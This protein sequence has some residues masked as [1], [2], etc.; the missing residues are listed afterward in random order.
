MISLKSHPLSSSKQ[1]IDRIVRVCAAVEKERERAAYKILLFREP[2]LI[3]SLDLFRG[4]DWQTMLFG[5]HP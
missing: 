3:D 5:T 4:F 1:T 2:L